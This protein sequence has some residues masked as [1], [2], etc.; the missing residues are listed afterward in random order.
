MSDVSSRCLSLSILN[1][2]SQER[3]EVNYREFHLSL[4]AVFR[5]SE[6]NIFTVQ[7]EIIFNTFSACLQSNSFF[8]NLGLNGVLNFNFV[9]NVTFLIRFIIAQI[10]STEWRG[11]WGG[12]CV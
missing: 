8:K 11:G 10:F 1:G 3:S 12:S 4:P 9:R 2:S 5:L 7:T 6:N